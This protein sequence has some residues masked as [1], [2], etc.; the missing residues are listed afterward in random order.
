MPDKKRPSNSS[1]RAGRFKKRLVGPEALL[2]EAPILHRRISLLRSWF[3]ESKISDKEFVALSIIATL[4]HRFPTTW[5]GSKL[6]EALRTPSLGFP[7]SS[8][9]WELDPKILNRLKGHGT[10]GE[11]LS[12]FTLRSTPLSVNRTLLAWGSDEYQLRLFFHIPRPREVLDQQVK[13]ER[14]VT[15]LIRE[16]EIS[17]YILGERDHLGFTLHD[18]IHADHFFKDN[19]HYQ[20]QVDFYRLLHSAMM[21][22]DFDE[23]LRNEEFERE[24]EYLISDMNAYP[25]HLMKCLKSALEH[26]SPENRNY[27][28]DW[29]KRNALSDDLK[30]ALTALNT[31]NYAAERYDGIVLK[32]LGKIES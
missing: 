10:L 6:P 16:S 18:L 30:E 12:R 3:E 15:V 23:A 13:G 25:I 21:A 32:E 4:S 26:Y 29:I 31:P 20:G 19:I 11:V 17:K 28:E 9:P 7:V 27:F 8:I 5:V 14:C 1:S 24:F 22:G 2:L